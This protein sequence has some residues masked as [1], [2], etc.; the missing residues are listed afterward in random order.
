MEA[1]CRGAREAGGLTI[2]ILPGDDPRDANA[3]VAVPVATG[4]GFARNAVI[5]RAAETMIAVGGGH[6]TLSEIA[7][8][9]RFGTPVVALGS[10]DLPEPLE[11]A[12]GPEEAVEKAFAALKGR[13]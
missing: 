13:P 8:A 4:L 2:G 3:W 6:G 7:L 12:A 11:R 1:S 5:A 10:W 9:L